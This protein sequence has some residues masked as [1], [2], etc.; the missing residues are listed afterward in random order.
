MLAGAGQELRPGASVSL[1]LT[2]P[3][4]FALAS[5]AGCAPT[6]AKRADPLAALDSDEPQWQQV[7]V[8]RSRRPVGNR[9]DI[10]WPL[11]AALREAAPLGYRDC[12]R[13]APLSCMASARRDGAVAALVWMGF[14]DDSMY[15]WAVLQHRDG[16]LT[17]YYYDSSPC[18][19]IDPSACG[20]LLQRSE[21]EAVSALQSD[22]TKQRALCD[23]PYFGA[24][25]K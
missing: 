19:G 15:G 17:R 21:C 23:K 20:Y 4:M 25:R 1:R 24:K 3:L 11:N 8:D 6:G 12:S 10:C 5:A 13:D 22:A 14:G 16:S 7:L 2:V 18:G 9:D